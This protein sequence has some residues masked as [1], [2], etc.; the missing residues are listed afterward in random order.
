MRRWPDS[1]RFGWSEED[2]GVR[3]RLTEIARSIQ[4]E[5]AFYRSLV[6]DPRTPLVAKALL[7]LAV[8]YALLPVDLI[9]DGIPVI[10]YLD[11]LVVIPLLVLAG[12]RL[13]P[14][15]VQEEC[16]RVGQE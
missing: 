9:P 12:L 8:G 13:V 16:R 10:G 4:D 14:D 11:D 3:Q 2:R 15:E 7:G 6:A 1:V 5:L